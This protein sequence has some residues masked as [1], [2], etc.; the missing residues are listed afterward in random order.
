[1]LAEERGQSSWLDDLNLLSPGEQVP[2]HLQQAASAKSNDQRSVGLRFKHLVGMEQKL[3]G[4]WRRFRREP[5]D[6]V[7]RLFLEDAK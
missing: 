4:V 5:P 2:R 6:N 1:M 7:D 3:R